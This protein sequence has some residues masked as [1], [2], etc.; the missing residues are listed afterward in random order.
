MRNILMVEDDQEITR[1]LRLHFET[2]QYCLTNCTTGR[3][4]VANLASNSYDL[5]ILFEKGEKY[6]KGTDPR[7]PGHP[8]IFSAAEVN[9]QPFPVFCK[10]P[11][12]R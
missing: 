5:V 12:C 10:Q 4:A 3:E 2:A 11:G 7:D 8:K 1:L 6:I 9:Y